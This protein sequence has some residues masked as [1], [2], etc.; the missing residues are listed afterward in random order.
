MDL[1]LKL[2]KQKVK[3]VIDLAIKSVKQYKFADAEND[4][5][6]KRHQHWPELNKIIT[7]KE[8]LEVE[9][10]YDKASDMMDE[11]IKKKKELGL[12]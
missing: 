8:H 6:R 2:Y 9:K 1:N 4:K 3:E 7:D 10:L 5:W 12:E 11:V